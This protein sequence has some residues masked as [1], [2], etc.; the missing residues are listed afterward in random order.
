[1]AVFLTTVSYISDH[2]TMQLPESAAKPT[3]AKDQALTSPP[4]VQTEA[5]PRRFERF[6]LLSRVAR[7]GMGEVY[8]ATAAG[9]EGA[10][11]PLIVKIIRPDHAEDRSFKARFLDEARIQA[12]LQH[13]GVAQILEATTD[14]S[15]APYVVVE[16][17]EGRNLSEVR[18]R[19]AQLGLRIGWPEAMA[20]GVCLGESLTHV[21]ERTCPDGRPLEIVHRDLSPQNVM[22]GYGGEV[23]LIDFGTARGQNRR[24][25]TISG[26]VFAK[27]GYVAPEVANNTPGG[28]PA[29]LYA[30][31]VVLW[32]LI[33]GR[34]FLTGEATEHMAAVG[35][36]KRSLPP[37]AQLI[38]CPAEIDQLLARLTATRIEDRYPSARVATQDIV[39]ILQRAPS[40]AD[41]DRSV[42]GRISDLLRR[43]YPAEPARS[44]A[45]FARRVAEARSVEVRPAPLPIASPEPPE[46]NDPLVLAGTRYRLGR[47]IGQGAMGVVYE[48]EHL[49]LGRRV[50]LKLLDADSLSE[51]ARGRFRFEARAIAQIQ[52]DNLVSIYD[53]GVCQDGRP[54][55]AMERLHGESLDV[56]LLRGGR[57]RVEAA[58]VH[59]LAA[60]RALEAAHR[61]GVVHRDVKPANLFLTDGGELKVLDFGVAKTTSGPS[62]ESP[63]E[64]VELVGTPEYMAPEQARGE[65]DARSDVYALASVIYE[66]VTGTLPFP[67][68]SV[69]AILASKAVQRPERPSLR[70]PDAG[71]PPALDKLLLAALDPEPSR[72]PQSVSAL[73]E[74]L[75]RVRSRAVTAVVRRRSYGRATVAAVLAGSLA[76]LAIAGARHTDLFQAR[77]SELATLRT[78]SSTGLGRVTDAAAQRLEGA[79]AS[80]AARAEPPGA[81]SEPVARALIPASKVVQPLASAVDAPAKAAPALPAPMATVTPEPAALA[82]SVPS[83]PSTPTPEPREPALAR[84]D[85]LERDGR[86]LRALEVLRDAAASETASSE[87]LS[88][89]T[90]ALMKTGA[91]GEAQRSARRRVS[92]DP[93][94]EARLE[95]ARVERAMGNRDRA[96]ELVKEVLKDPAAPSEAKALLSALSPAGRVALRD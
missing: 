87:L 32:E 53:Y 42:R 85:A 73:A 82:D 60:C 18:G 11:R 54:F 27:P 59:A 3:S 90:Q 94:A 10:E 58:L 84:A 62:A 80:L 65:G 46:A 56:R 77:F 36:G 8:L 49:D 26:I 50:A 93:S 88:R 12:Q 69:V 44:R 48:A 30:F 19:A 61:V 17:I 1:M 16:H 64:G 71:I 40:L 24:C 75:E 31:G 79:I 15:G 86:D 7:G 47:P 34:R 91:W 63:A 92:A 20:I 83:T 37:L 72:R 43:L 39:R 68:E 5:L 21:H 70:A 22:I 23:K 2:R 25:Q 14:T 96:L 81:K 51:K 57:L 6:T 4:Q 74:E 33:A 66:L 55:Y 95:L 29:D 78:S 41:G 76:L 9:I 89:L 38:G 35:A 67:A 13:P 45:D 28:V 52:H